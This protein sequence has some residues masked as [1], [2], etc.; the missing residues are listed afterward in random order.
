MVIVRGFTIAMDSFAV[1]FS[2]RSLVSVSWTVKVEAPPV[3]GV[4]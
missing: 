3:E 1:A 4:P 2:D